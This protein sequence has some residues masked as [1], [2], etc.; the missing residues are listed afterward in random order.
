MTVLSS[1]SDTITVTLIL[2]SII[3]LEAVLVEDRFTYWSSKDTQFS[4]TGSGLRNF[5]EDWC[6]KIESSLIKC[7]EI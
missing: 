3:L 6:D 2:M 5:L 4:S 1:L 7:L